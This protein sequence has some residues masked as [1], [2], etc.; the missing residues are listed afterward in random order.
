MK[1]EDLIVY[2]PFLIFLFF[3]ILSRAFKKRPENEEDQKIEQEDVYSP[4]PEAKVY[5]QK[6]KPVNIEPVAKKR[7]SLM[8]DHF[9]FSDNIKERSLSQSVEKRHV[10]SSLEGSEYTELLQDRFSDRSIKFTKKHSKGASLLRD[11]KSLKK[12]IILK[13][14]LDK[15]F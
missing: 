11:Q 3:S 14:I 4:K 6:P 1:S 9:E 13:E 8:E 7:H 12:A 15:K 5:K 10:E 2:V